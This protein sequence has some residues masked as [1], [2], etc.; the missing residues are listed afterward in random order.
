MNKKDSSHKIKKKFFSEGKN[1][2]KSFNSE[3]NT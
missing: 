2:G 3:I 1:D